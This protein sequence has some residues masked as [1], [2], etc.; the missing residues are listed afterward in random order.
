VRV[1]EKRGR[2]VEGVWKR[3]AELEGFTAAREFEDEVR[4]KDRKCRKGRECRGR[5]G[6]RCPLSER[7]GTEPKERDGKER[8]KACG[9]EGLGFV[10]WDGRGGKAGSTTKPSGLAHASAVQIPFGSVMGKDVNPE[11][12][13]FKRG[14]TRHRKKKGSRRE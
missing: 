9:K 13:R 3:L 7:R 14:K 1:K 4:E 8:K 11:P 10:G 2:A 6:R 12:H 5:G